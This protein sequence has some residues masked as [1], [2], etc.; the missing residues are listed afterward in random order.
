[1]FGFYSS[2][3]NGS[4]DN[5][6]VLHRYKSRNT[7]ETSIVTS[8]FIPTTFTSNNLLKAVF[9]HSQ[10]ST[11]KVCIYSCRSVTHDKLW[12]SFLF[13]IHTSSISSAIFLIDSSD[14][15]IIQSSNL[16]PQ[17]SERAI[18]KHYMSFQLKGPFSLGPYIKYSP[19]GG[20]SSSSAIWSHDLD[21]VETADHS[22]SA[23][24]RF[25]FIYF[26]ESKRKLGW[27]N[28]VDLRTID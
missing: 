21:G 25:F 23:L 20:A 8:I 13:H 15:A 18:G 19:S 9:T 28:D 12:P 4:N 14:P 16:A 17:T 26:I 22:L 7:H 1:M 24:L 5:L 11:L 6:T 10:M 2:W 27:G 3:L